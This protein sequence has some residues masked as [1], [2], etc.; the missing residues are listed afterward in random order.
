[1]ARPGEGMAQGAGK[2]FWTRWW[3]WLLAAPV[4]CCLL[5]GA[6]SAY[7][8][9]TISSNPVYIGALRRAEANGAVKQQ[10]GTPLMVTAVTS[11]KISF[12]GGDTQL[13][14]EVSGPKGSGTLIAVAAGSEPESLEIF[15]MKLKVSAN[16]QEIRL[17]GTGGAPQRR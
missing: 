4:L 10:L 12:M 2:P 7:M 17:D 5:G 15:N 1:M 13:V 8:H 14:L 6:T 11:A 16:G 9:A 3:V